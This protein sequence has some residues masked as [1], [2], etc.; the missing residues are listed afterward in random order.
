VEGDDKPY[1]RIKVL[2]TICDGIKTALKQTDICTSSGYIPCGQKRDT[3]KR[4]KA[5]EKQE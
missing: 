1:A 4:R 3:E 2:T 5:D